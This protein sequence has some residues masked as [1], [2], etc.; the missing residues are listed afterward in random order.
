MKP[1]SLLLPIIVFLT[2]GLISVADAQVVNSQDRDIGAVGAAGSASNN[3]SGGFTVTGSG[4]DIWGTADEF[5]YVY[6]SLDGDMAIVG[7][8]T[9]VDF[10]DGWAKAG[11]MARESLDANSRNFMVFVTP[12]DLSGIQWRGTTG[13]NSDYL[14]GGT[15]AI[16]QWVKLVRSGNT[17]SGYRSADGVNWTL[18]GSTTIAL[19]STLYV[20]L[21]VTSHHDG[22]LC[23]AT[24]DN[25]THTS[26]GGGGG[27]S[28][29]P[30]APT[31]LT[32]TPYSS[33]E[34]LLSWTDNAND[35]DYFRVER[36]TDGVN[37]QVLNP[38][39]PNGATNMY[40]F[41]LSP[42]THYW[43]RIYAVNNAGAS[44][45]SN[46]AE[47]TTPSS[48]SG[49]TSGWQDQD[50]G[51]V[52]AAGNFSQSG[53]S[54]TVSGSGFD[55]W[56]EHDEFHY[57]YQRGTNNVQIV[58]RITGM[59]NTSPWAKAGVMI[60]ESQIACY[61]FSDCE[62]YEFDFAKNVM[63]A[64]TPS[65][66]LAFQWRSTSATTPSYIDAG[67]ASA[68]VWVKL[69]K[70]GTTFTGYR[71]PD[72]VNWTQVGTATVTMG[73]ASSLSLGLAVTSHNDGIV[74]MA[75]FDN[76]TINNG[77][78][79]GGG[80]G[81]P[82]APSGLIAA[83]TSSN[84]VSLTWQ[85]NSTIETGFILERSTNGTSFIQ[86]GAFPANTQTAVEAVVP[87]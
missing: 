19:P 73:S 72:G 59:G 38:R 28:G 69:V 55:I 60:R 58:A 26:S 15:V 13:G 47:V 6:F 24:F 78:D 81:I 61:G 67:P 36:S 62:T 80:A 23:T 14:G 32:A 82:A 31:G 79:S 10:S 41:P 71:S 85:D 17:F 51:A 16:P 64:L 77:R 12:Q 68:P 46:V 56:G 25:V 86:I 48:G 66:G 1:L 43:Y 11:L 3:G 75:N 42:S 50:I 45:P 22:T 70:S 21:A 57:A 74:C 5:H 49:G 44:P 2:S 4:A 40:D 27:T 83:A 7:R 33:T 76:V 65:H 18:I 29:V 84:R 37:F 20:G 54:Y 39:P 87:G 63:L 53:N 30:T 34:V 35:E 9:G 52:S 8:V